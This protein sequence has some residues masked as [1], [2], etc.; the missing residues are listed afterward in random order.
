MSTV[1]IGEKILIYYK[2]YQYIVLNGFHL[3][4]YIFL[5][6]SSFFNVRHS[7]DPPRIKILIPKEVFEN[8]LFTE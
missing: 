7:L 1:E 8:L 6:Q 5:L 2:I 3:S 4:L